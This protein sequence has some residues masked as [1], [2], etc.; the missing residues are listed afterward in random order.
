M[1][2][3]SD[4]KRNIYS[5]FGED[6]IIEKIFKIISPGKDPW[7]VE[8]G[9]WDGVNF[10]NTHNVIRNKKWKGVLIESK[11]KRYRELLKT[12]ENNKNVLCLNRFVNFQGENSLDN[13]LS[14]TPIPKNFNLL[15]VDIDGNDYYIW[16]SLKKYKPK[17]VIIELNPTI[18]HDIE[19]IQARNFG[20]NQGSSLLAFFELAKRK[21]YE[22]V[23]TTDCNAFFVKKE[24]YK[25]FKIADN[26]VSVMHDNKKYITRLYQFY[27]G[28]IALDGCKKLIWHGVSFK[29]KD[30]Q[31]L[32]NFLRKLPDKFNIVFTKAYR[33]DFEGL[34]ALWKTRFKLNQ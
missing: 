25:L 7:C 27:D 17:V 12:Y 31:I 28:T 15:S 34:S 2:K 23:A 29:D 3:L 21:K 22:L 1:K 13:I 9:A 5:Q 10:S 32:P 6:G 16:E 11:G 4:F 14:K 33:R 26:S 18:P 20:V 19:F 24:L 30:I 8:F